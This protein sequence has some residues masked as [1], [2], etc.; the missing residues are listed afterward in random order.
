[1]LIAAVAGTAVAGSGPTANTAGKADK[2]L[3]KA[4]KALKIAKA[5]DKEEGPKGETGSQGPKGDTGDPGTF[6]STVPS[7]DTIRGV[8]GF[9]GDAH[10][11]SDDYR[12]LA[13]LPIP[14]TGGFT[15]NDINVDGEDEEANECTGSAAIP[16]APAGEVCIYVAASDNA[17]FIHGAPV[18][19]GSSLGFTLNWTTT[20]AGDT[21]VE[22]TWAYTAP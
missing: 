8:V 13:S 22:G 6:P 17:D 21:F 16:T 18:S 19:G 12:A 20:G 2:A 9:D 4:K 7:G 5:A 11:A 14:V 3:K 10:A 1:M 15:N